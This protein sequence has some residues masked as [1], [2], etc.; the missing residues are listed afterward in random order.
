MIGIGPDSLAAAAA[1][2]TPASLSDLGRLAQVIW[3]FLSLS[4]F[5]LGGGNTLLAEY[6]HLTVDQLCWLTS[7][8]FS[9]LYALA[10]AAPGP[11]SMIVGLLAMGAAWKEGPLWGLLSAFSGELAILLPSTLL[12]VAASL[13]WNRL[14]DSPWRVAFERGLGPI[15][16]GILFAVGLKILTTANHGPLAYLVSF[17][18]CALM[19]RT[20]I[21]PLWFMAVA[22][23]LGGLGVI[24]R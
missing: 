12:M 6:H 17:V 13:S 23:V 11:S 2:C 3:T 9:D 10:E 8:Q 15:T 16:L 1:H 22:G 7:A 4:L 14:R 24:N 5:S 18:V 19:L 20:R 21:S